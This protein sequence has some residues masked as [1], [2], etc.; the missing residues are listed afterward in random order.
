[1][2]SLIH[3]TGARENNLKNISVAIP[4]NS[5]TVISGPSGAGKTSL[6]IGTLAR[7]SAYRIETLKALHRRQAPAPALRRPHVDSIANLSP[8]AALETCATIDQQG[9]VARVLGMDD[10]LARFAALQPASGSCPHGHGEFCAT[11]PDY[12]SSLIEKDGEDGVTALIACFHF[13]TKKANTTGESAAEKIE[14]LRKQGYSLFVVHGKIIDVEQRQDSAAQLLEPASGE[15]SS[16]HVIIDRLD[17]SESGRQRI[18]ESITLAFTL[19]GTVGVAKLSEGGIEAVTYYSK[20]GCCPKCGYGGQYALRS[21][22]DCAVTSMHES[23]AKCNTSSSKDLQEVCDSLRHCVDLLN[24]FG[25]SH[26]TLGRSVSSLSRKER[27]CLR[28]CQ[29]LC[30][31]TDGFT[32]ILDEPLSGLPFWISEAL[33]DT[34]KRLRDRGNTVILVDNDPLTLSHADYSIVL[35]PYGGE[36]GGNV[37]YSGAGKAPHSTTALQVPALRERP[38][39]DNSICLRK[40]CSDT[41]QNVSVEFRTGALNVVYGPCGSG[42]NSL[43]YKTLCEAAAAHSKVKRVVRTSL[44]RTAGPNYP[45]VAGYL[46]IYPEL[47]DLFASMLL[48]K[49]RGY[50]SKTFSFPHSRSARADAQFSPQVLE[51]RFKEL[52]IAELLQ[53]S[54]RRAAEYLG[55]IRE[56]SSAFEQARRLEIDYLL[57]GRPLAGLSPGERQRLLLVK[58]LMPAKCETLYVLEEPSMGLSYQEISTVVSVLRDLTRSGNTI[59]AV[60]HN[61]SFICAADYLVELGTGAPNWGSASVY[62]G[63]P[64]DLAASGQSIMANAVRER[65][66]LV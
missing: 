28:L 8:V 31:G 57:L 13:S 22:L 2:S 41:L 54:F 21:F 5:L 52:N 42:T 39:T 40:I 25:L 63:T 1:M 30:S 55:N 34:L 29:F 7:E 66:R 59:V 64:A 23:L 38:N 27:Q 43:V 12:V 32:Y 10:A 35:G 6:A 18:S 60:D 36:D 48:S 61:L 45:I 9:T 26:L 37:V 4:K 46:G 47:Q 20:T 56:F 58:N 17:S 3:I 11:E 44:Q 50:D 15:D 49:M 33:I 14:A 16:L 53:C 19:S 24:A 65:L 62:C 51:V